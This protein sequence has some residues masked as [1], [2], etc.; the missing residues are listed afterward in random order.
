MGAAFQ[1][2]GQASRLGDRAA[3]QGS[4]ADP[5]AGLVLTHGSVWGPGELLLAGQMD[6]H[7]AS[8]FSKTPEPVVRP[9]QKHN[10]TV[11]S[12]CGLP[13]GEGMGTRAHMPSLCGLC[14]VVAGGHLG[15][16]T[17]GPSPALVPC[18]PLVPGGQR[19]HPSTSP[20]SSQ[21]LPGALSLQAHLRPFCC[22]VCGL[23]VLEAAV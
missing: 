1:A 19:Q 18:P 20:A 3:S 15:V 6:G 23:G 8:G 17:E 14:R 7:W 16:C 5:G 22:A 12:P 2:K 11:F 4:N 13:W 9:P 10:T 21:V